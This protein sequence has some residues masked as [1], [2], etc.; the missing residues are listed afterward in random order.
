MT[1]SPSSLIN[2]LNFPIA[3]IIFFALSIVV[4]GDEMKYQ[5]VHGWPQL[6]DNSI[7]DEVSAV[8]VDSESNIYVL[9]RGGRKWPDNDILDKTLIE[10][11][12][13]YIFD[14]RTG[15]LLKKWGERLFAW[16]HGL[17]I[18]NKDNIWVTDVALHQVYKFSHDGKLLLTL[19]VSGVPADDPSHFNRPT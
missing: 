10:V 12:T 4:S 19:G 16:P 3:L 17:T 7:L 9:Q 18:D 13:I 6:P 5:V 14:G 8:A 1:T 2:K 15:A 11:P